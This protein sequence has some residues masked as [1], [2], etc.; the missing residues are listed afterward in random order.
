MKDKSKII[1]EEY[2]YLNRKYP[3]FMK[4]LCDF[5]FFKAMVRAQDKFMEQNPNNKIFI[6]YLYSDYHNPDKLA[7]DQ[8]MA[9]VRYLNNALNRMIHIFTYIDT[10]LERAVFTRPMSDGDY[11]FIKRTIDCCRNIDLGLLRSFHSEYDFEKGTVK[12]SS[13]KLDYFCK[14]LIIKG[15][16][17]IG[18]NKSLFMKTNMYRTFVTGNY[19]MDVTTDDIKLNGNFYNGE[20]L[21]TLK[22]SIGFYCINEKF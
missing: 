11:L 2:N 1:E 16:K 8:T 14:D 3:N 17:E 10:D 12:H 18:F 9:F 20:S 13:Y 5:S 21:K 22:E 15:N 4:I 7:V 19:L 6:Y